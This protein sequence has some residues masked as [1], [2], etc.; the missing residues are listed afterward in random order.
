MP[1]QNT[2]KPTEGQMQPTVETATSAH[3]QT[4]LGLDGVVTV[5]QRVRVCRINCKPFIEVACGMGSVMVE[6]SADDCQH[7]SR[8]LAT[9]ATVPEEEAAKLA[10][11]KECVRKYEERK[12]AKALAA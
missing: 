9:V 2:L 5:A 10:E 6:L 7:L 1:E 3:M 11:L 12:K 8:L 4:E